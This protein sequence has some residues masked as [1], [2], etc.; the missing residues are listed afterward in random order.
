MKKLV[1]G[2][3]FLALFAV[4]AT[5]CFI[6]SGDDSGDDTGDDVADRTITASWSLHN[7]GTAQQNLPCPPGTTTAAVY[8]APIDTNYITID[9]ETRVDLFDCNDRSGTTDP[10][11][12]DKYQT[13]IELTDNVTGSGA[14]I[15]HGN[16][17]TASPRW[18]DT[19][20][21]NDREDIVDL[22]SSSNKSISFALIADGGYFAAGWSLQGNQTCAQ[23]G[24]DGVSFLT[25][26]VAT[27]T[28]SADDLF[29]CA[30]GFG[31]TG[32]FIN[33][34]YMVALS[35]KDGAGAA[36][37]STTITGAITGPNKVTDLGDVVL[38]IDP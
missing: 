6:S 33:G 35:A 19:L 12:S 8:T 14:T 16:V 24:A 22:T 36:G 30:A 13:W 20:I 4:Q 18:P 1:L 29:N 28:S 11:F 7:L 27:G 15:V 23:A 2:T 10:L 34:N 38:G 17:Y 26:E 31:I 3:L 21:E 5:G 32:A 25:T 9:A 37:A